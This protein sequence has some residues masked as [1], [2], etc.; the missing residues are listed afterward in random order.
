MLKKILFVL[1]SL[2]G[3]IT[4]QQFW[5]AWVLI[6]LLGWGIKDAQ[7]S[8]GTLIGF[9][10]YVYLAISIYGKRLHDLDR[11]AKALIVPFVLHAVLVVVGGF[12]ASSAMSGGM[13]L[14]TAM[15]VMGV[16]GLLP[17]LVWLGYAFMVGMP[18]GADSDNRYGPS[19][20]LHP[21]GALSPGKAT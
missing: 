10:A 17:T 7:A 21:A 11:S 16:V 3:R 20:R 14:D 5:I 1:L 15:T 19:P 18:Q 13:R 2:N 12:I 9:V 6:L 4:R 8:L